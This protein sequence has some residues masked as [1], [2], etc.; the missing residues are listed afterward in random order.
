[1]QAVGYALKKLSLYNDV[2]RGPHRMDMSEIQ[3]RLWSMTLGLSLTSEIQ[4]R[5]KIEIQTR[6]I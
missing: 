1:M 4:M 2:S 3:E 5:Y 6:D